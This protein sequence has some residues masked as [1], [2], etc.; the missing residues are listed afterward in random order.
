MTN[1]EQDKDVQFRLSLTVFFCKDRY[2]VWG[3]LVAQQAPQLTQK[4]SLFF[5]DRG[6]WR[7]LRV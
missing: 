4:R 3:G 6:V 5:A 1:K 7:R 2:L